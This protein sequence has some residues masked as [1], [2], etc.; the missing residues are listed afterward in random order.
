VVP[1]SECAVRLRREGFLTALSHLTINSPLL[2]LRTPQK[3]H[4]DG[5]AVAWTVVGSREARR[6]RMGQ[7]QYRPS[8]TCLSAGTDSNAEFN[9]RTRTPLVST[10]ERFRSPA[11]KM[12]RDGSSW[13]TQGVWGELGG[14]LMIRGAVV[15][16]RA[17]CHERA[18]TPIV[19]VT[20]LTKDALVITLT[21]HNTRGAWMVNKE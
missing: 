2:A 1:C 18:V 3:Q 16:P 4:L 5:E 15:P 9:A 21:P 12:T 19:G 11:K 6:R 17:C 14:G 10:N 13:R 7:D 8:S 20:D